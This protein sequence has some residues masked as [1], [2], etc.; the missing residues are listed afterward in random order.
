MNAP[1]QVGRFRTLL[2]SRGVDRGSGE[3]TRDDEQVCCCCAGATLPA[4]KAG[5]LEQASRYFV[6]DLGMRLPM[7]GLSTA[8]LPQARST[9][10]N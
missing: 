4:A 6:N 1:F 7:A 8:G 10:A 9:D 3:E 2:P 5:T